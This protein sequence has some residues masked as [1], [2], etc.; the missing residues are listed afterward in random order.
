MLTGSRLLIS[1]VCGLA[2]GTLPAVRWADCS[3]ALRAGGCMLFA[4]ARAADGTFRLLDR[5]D[6]LSALNALPYVFIKMFLAVLLSAFVAFLNVFIAVVLLISA[7]DTFQSVIGPICAL[8][9]GA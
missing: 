8:A 9:R 1:A 6:C 5:A 4:D 2:L 7:D 3:L